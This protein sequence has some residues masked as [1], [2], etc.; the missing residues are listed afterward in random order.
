[1][2]ARVLKSLVVVD[3]CLDQLVDAIRNLCLF[4]FDE[5]RH[6]SP[7]VEDLIDELS[8]YRAV[9]NST[10]KSFWSEV[11][12]AADYDVSLKKKAEKNPEKYGD[13]T[14]EGG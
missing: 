8:S 1:M 6:G 12:G 5:F 9:I 10:P 4:G 13:S 14:W 3:M 11:E 7:V 2:A